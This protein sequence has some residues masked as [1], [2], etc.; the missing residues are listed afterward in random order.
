MLHDLTVDLARD[1]FH[2][3]AR[4]A[5]CRC[6][7]AEIGEERVDDRADQLVAAA[8]VPVDR[9]VGD[10]ELGR[11]LAHRERVDTIGLDAVAAPRRRSARVR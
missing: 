8:D 3:G 5:P 6:D 4:R 7:V 1:G 11:Q 10:V 2:P 9:R